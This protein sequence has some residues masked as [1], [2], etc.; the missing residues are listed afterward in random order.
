MSMRKK[1]K[2]GDKLYR[3]IR[4]HS[5][6]EY[7]VTGVREREKSSQY[8]VKCDSCKDHPNCELLIAY[9]D[10]DKLIHI[11]MLND[12]EDLCRSQRFWHENEGFYFCT[13]KY[14]AEKERAQTYLKEA[15]DSVAKEKLILISA[16]KRLKEMQDL[17]ALIESKSNTEGT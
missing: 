1:F 6:F 9:N 4:Y 2:I 10:Y 14:D 11:E 17:M 15:K 7:T 3:A 16:E 8:E 12:D 5:V 13:T